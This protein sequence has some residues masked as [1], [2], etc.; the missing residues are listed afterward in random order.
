[1]LS[2]K[3][4]IAFSASVVLAVFIALTGYALDRAFHDS[5]REA[6]RERLLGQVYL[7][8]A[9]AEVDSQGRL[10][11]PDTLSESRFSLPGSGLYGIITDAQGAV[12]WRSTS[13]I[14]AETPYFTQLAPAQ[15]KFDRLESATGEEYFAHSLGV[16]WATEEQPQSFTFNVV[17]DLSA[18]YS[19]LGSYRGSLWGWLGAMALLLLGAQAFVL[20]WGLKPLKRVAREITAIEAGKNERVEGVYPPEIKL[21]TDNLNALLLHERSQQQRYR[22]ALADLAHSLKTPLSV[23]RGALANSQAD[24]RLSKTVEDEVARMNHIVEYQLQRAATAGRSQLASPVAVKPV[25]AR[26]VESLSKV[27]FD[28][29]VETAFAVDEQAAFRGDEGDLTELLGNLL[30]NAYKW[31]RKN[32]RVA[33]SRNAR[34]LVLSVEDDGPGIDGAQA[35]RLLQRG[36]RGDEAAPGHGIGLAI[37]RD[38]VQAYGGEIE[39]GSS[40]LGGTAMRLKL[41]G[42]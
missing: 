11:M 6:R 4:R 10:M 29:G 38:I 32:V 26:I 7:L 2:L 34:N 25:A 27:Y 17:E 35:N 23:M 36:V 33:A 9:A 8:I 15:Q 37:V 1:M 24:P 19:Q 42:R 20:R 13:A 30:D 22:D 14:G 31:C 21:L 16:S 18:F 41:P 5:S 28:K 3:A 39:I 12:V 40:G